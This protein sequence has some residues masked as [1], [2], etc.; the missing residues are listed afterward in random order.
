MNKYII[1]G[2]IILLSVSSVSAT[3]IDTGT[4]TVTVTVDTGGCGSSGSITDGS[5]SIDFSAHPW[6]EEKF[7][8]ARFSSNFGGCSPYCSGFNLGKPQYI[9]TRSG[10]SDFTVYDRCA[11][12]DR[13]T[14]NDVNLNL[15]LTSFTF[16]FNPYIDVPTGNKYFDGSSTGH[17]IFYV[18]TLNTGESISGD[19]CNIDWVKLQYYNSSGGYE[20][21][22]Y[23]NTTGASEYEFLDLYNDS[24]YRLNF[25]NGHTYEFASNV[26]SIYNYIDLCEFY[27]L[28]LLDN[29]ANLL[30]DPTTSIFRDTSEL[31]YYG[32]DNPVQLQIGT[33]VNESDFLDIIIWTC[34]GAVMYSD[35]VE[36]IEKDLYH[37]SIS[38]NMDVHVI[39]DNTGADISGAQVALSQNC[40]I[41][42][43]PPNTLTYSGH[44]HFT[45]LSNNNM[46][47]SVTKTGYNIYSNTITVGSIFNCWSSGGRVTISLNATT[48]NSTDDFNNGTHDDTPADGEGEETL[49]DNHAWGCGVYFK[50]TDG[51]IVGSILDTDAYVDMYYWTKGCDATLKFQSQI[52]TYWYTDLEY[53]VS[54]NTYEYRRILNANFS[55]HTNSYRGFIYNETCDCNDIQILR[56]LNETY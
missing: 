32:N 55:D 18:G 13:L 39:D 38:W 53:S 37:P 3:I 47:I 6:P 33:T 46:G 44:A 31:I 23:L 10:S 8:R 26:T 45:G 25:S 11:G 50:N 42:D 56:V 29:C 52:Y 1:I 9:C 7:C 36:T 48:G 28:N 17:F 49:P 35:Y 22:D 51:K 30:I 21:M 20:Y 43:A 12:T 40:Y 4:A 14:S 2:L 27:E 54:N 16:T 34:D 15:G 5:F 24:L 19:I 41:G